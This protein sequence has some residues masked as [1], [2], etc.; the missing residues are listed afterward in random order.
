MDGACSV[1]KRNGRG[2]YRY[3]GRLERQS[4]IAGGHVDDIPRREIAAQ[5]ALRQRT[6]ELVLDRPLQGPGTVHRVETRLAEQVARRGVE[7]EPHVA[8]SKAFAQEA[9]LDVYDLADVRLA[10]R[11][12]HDHLIDA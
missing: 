5:D 11:V 6:L 10:E 3:R 7:F 12:E 9:E 2:L 1:E 4:A 8:V